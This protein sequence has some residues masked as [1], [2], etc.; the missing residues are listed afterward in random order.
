M[1]GNIVSKFRYH[2]GIELIKSKKH[3]YYFHKNGM[4]KLKE[5]YSDENEYIL[6]NDNGPAQIEFFKNGM[7][8]AIGYYNIKHK[9]KHRICGPA[10]IYYNDKGLISNTEWYYNNKLYTF[11]VN[12]WLFNNNLNYNNMNEDDYN[13][14]WFEIL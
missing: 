8:K 2:D 1:D 12:Y 14:M 10:F 11:Y 7:I 9:G 5:Y 6:S 4:L 3:G 13:R